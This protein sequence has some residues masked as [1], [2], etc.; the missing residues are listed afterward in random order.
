MLHAMFS[1][2]GHSPIS[3][4]RGA[5]WSSSKCHRH[6][7]ALVLTICGYSGLL[8]LSTRQ[9]DRMI[10][11]NSLCATNKFTYMQTYHEYSYS[12]NLLMFPSWLHSIFLPKLFLH[13][14]DVLVLVLHVESGSEAEFRLQEE[15]TKTS[16]HLD[17]LNRFLS[18]Y[19]ATNNYSM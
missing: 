8:N 11:K 7:H 4:S 14:E 16:Y 1:Y 2:C 18:S 15:H 3:V 12:P 13:P 6:Q 19:I 5:V 9:F 10:S 17:R